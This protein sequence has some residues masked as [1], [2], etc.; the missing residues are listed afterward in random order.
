MITKAGFTTE[1]NNEIT[2]NKKRNKFTA[3]SERIDTR[4]IKGG[5]GEEEG[6]SGIIIEDDVI[7]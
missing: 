7:N 1:S 2:S 6:G 3:C 4:A 5:N